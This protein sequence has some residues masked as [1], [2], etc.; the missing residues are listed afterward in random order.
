MK[1]SEFNFSAP[2]VQAG[3]LLLYAVLDQGFLESACAPRLSTDMHSHPYFEILACIDGEYDIKLLDREDVRMVPGTMCLLPPETYHSCNAV[4]GNILQLALRF[5]YTRQKSS[6][7]RNDEPT[8][9]F[10]ACD[11]VMQSLDSPRILPDVGPLCG[12]LCDIRGEM[13]K[14]QIGSGVCAQLLI[15]QFFIRLIRRLDRQEMSA[16][17]T[18]SRI[19]DDDDREVRYQKIENYLSKNA[20]IAVTEEDMARELGLSSRQ[21]SRVLRSIYGMSFR[22]K[23]IETRLHRAVG[24]LTH[25][26]CPIEKVAS[27]VGYTTPSGFY[28]AFRKQF[29]MSAGEYRRLHQGKSKENIE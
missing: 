6:G 26:D 7:S 15:A 2:E 19:P 25:T 9:L 29:G 17:I 23:V 12:M 24:L 21:L 8:S 10:E 14:Q 16:N 20:G 13:Q 11:R 3:D 27:S 18:A 4:G 5:R 1:K 22:E 28:V